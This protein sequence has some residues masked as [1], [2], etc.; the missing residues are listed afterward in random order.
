MLCGSRQME[1][2]LLQ[3]SRRRATRWR[4]VFLELPVR[5]VFPAR[6]AIEVGFRSGKDATLISN[7]ANSVRNLV[8]GNRF[9]HVS[10]QTCLTVALGLL[11]LPGLALGQTFVQQVNNTP[12]G[13]ASV[14][15]TTPENAGDLNVVIVGVSESASVLSVTDSN[16]NN[17]V[18]A[19]EASGNGVG[20]AIYYAKNISVTTTNMPTVSVT[21]NAFQTSTPDVRVLEYTGFSSSNLTVDNWVGN[22][23]NNNPA[24]SGTVTTS[25][26]DLIVGAGSAVNEFESGGIPSG[27]TSRGI[28]G[29]GDVAMDSNGAVPAGSYQAGSN[30]GNGGWVMAAVA[31]SISGISGP[32]PTV[33]SI[34]PTS[35]PVAGGTAVAITGTNFLNGAIALFGTAPGGLAAANCVQAG[36]TTLNC[37][38]PDDNAGPKDVTVVNVDGQNASLAGAYTY[39]INNPSI[40]S[41]SPATTTTNG[42]T[43]ITITGSNFESGANVTVGGPLP[44][45]GNG[46]FGDNVKVVSGSTITITSPAFPAGTTADV[47][48]NNPDGGT[49]TDSGALTYTLGAG[50]IN[51]IQRADAAT[52]SSAASVPEQMTNP[53]GQG[54]LNVIVVGWGDTST[55]VSSVSDTEGN[56]YVQA[57]PVIQGTSLS[58]VIY[59][60]K[61]IK[62]DGAG[63]PNTIT[64]TFTGAAS[65]PDVR[66]LEYAGLDIN[67]PLDQGVS[68]FG[69][70][71]LADTGICTTTSP[72]ELIVAAA[73]VSSEVTAAGANFTTVDYTFNGDNVEQQLTSAVGSCE[74]TTAL[75]GG[76][77]VTQAV[78][79]KMGAA[80]APGF[81]LT[82]NPPTSQTVAAGSNASYA[83]TVGAVGGFTG[84]VGLACTGL[85]SGASCGFSPVSPVTAGPVTLT[86]STSASTPG[87]TSTVTITGSSSGLTNQTAQVT[88]TVNGAPNFTIAA[89]PTSATI[90]T[91]GGAASS[92]ISVNATGGF[93]GN[94][95]L[96][97]AVSGGGSPAPT[98][99]LNP[100]SVAPGTPS[101]LTVNTTA[102]TASNS[103]RSTGLF[104]ALLLPIGGI[105]LL[106]AG[107]SSRRKQLLGIMLICLLVAGFVF[108]TSCSSGST[109]TTTPPN[110]GTPPGTYT[111]TVTGMSGSLSAE[112]ATFTVTVQ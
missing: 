89:S 70:G 2:K 104:Y 21:L 57:L 24:S 86:I 90:S 20:V 9:R 3:F 48:V 79:F 96:T 83:L 66:Y 94:V 26:S 107:F 34:A 33:A 53:E 60:A 40:S 73:T 54:D 23:N 103:P 56:T 6:I 58:Q 100:A 78:S 77:W 50:P 11:L 55:Q 25:T 93:N 75:V 102:N 95:A 87:G 110:N 45:A 85:P 42:D 101:A 16:S 36:S 32:A 1:A 91:Q 12:S 109:T 76:N 14:T 69:N 99:S 8:T 47:T 27:L 43:L 98:C 31:F 65:S 30:V 52:G 28:N 112:T 97:C 19:S 35:G 67:S 22:S 7:E 41:I 39:I 108:M 51:Y 84:T 63:T 82:A 72:V 81:T 80:V 46:E 92:A 17:Y 62:G 15:F 18:L 44:H 13:T 105:T 68:N 4:E 37:N 64:V 111:V 49:A 5:N 71:S 88:L 61:N 106:G 74:A 59:Y 29:F 10:L 38:T